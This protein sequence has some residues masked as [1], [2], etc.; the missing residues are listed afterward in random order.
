MAGHTYHDNP[1][2]A[3]PLQAQ[4]Y[5]G[6]MH[7]SGNPSN[8]TKLPDTMGNMRHSPTPGLPNL[9]ATSLGSGL[10]EGEM[11]RLQGLF[12]GNSA[13]ADGRRMHQLLCH[14]HSC[15]IVEP[16]LIDERGMH[17]LQCHTLPL[18]YCGASLDGLERHASVAMPHSF[19]VLWW[20]LSG[21]AGAAGISC[22]ATLRAVLLWSCIGWIG[23]AC[24]SCNATLI[25]V[26]L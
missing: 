23:E 21:W 6:C 9:V 19:A 14:T 5:R 22:N 4:A 3:L 26:L 24:I 16:P 12:G 2:R 15:L 10:C 1:L 18:S 11:Q 25:A 8:R 13:W 7:C 20:S 17:Q